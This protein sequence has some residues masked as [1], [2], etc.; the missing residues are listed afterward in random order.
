[1]ILK[2]AE[3]LLTTI[4][5]TRDLPSLIIPQPPQLITKALWN[6][7]FSTTTQVLLL[8]E[9]YTEP[10]HWRL[11]PNCPTSLDIRKQTR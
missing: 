7:R 4:A 5:L 2:S 8:K 11:G 9:H 10:N 6:S 3:S 1:M